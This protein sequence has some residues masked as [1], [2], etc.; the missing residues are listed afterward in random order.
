MEISIRLKKEEIALAH[1]RN[2]ESALE[3]L[4]EQFEK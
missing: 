2:K 3:A 1:L 4:Q